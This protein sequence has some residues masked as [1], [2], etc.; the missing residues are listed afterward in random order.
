MLNITEKLI[1]V[2]RYLSADPPD[3]DDVA[4]LFREASDFLLSHS[5]CTEVV[6][7]RIGEAI[8][9]ILGLFLV[10]IVPS[11]PEVDDQLWVVVGDL[12]PAYLVCDDC[13][14]AASALQGYLFEM[15]RWI[16]AV[17]SGEPISGLIP[18]NVPPTAEWAA[19]LKRRLQ[20]IEQ[21]ILVRLTA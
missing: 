14:D 8:P 3:R 19:A 18:V 1:R 21:K 11:R 2:E 10:R 13:H 5:W 17:E 20:F 15:S 16:Q 4:G 12:P 7:G 9:G 6:E